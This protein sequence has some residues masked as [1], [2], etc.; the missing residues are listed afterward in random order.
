M[1]PQKISLMGLKE[2][3]LRVFAEILGL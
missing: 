1:V 3:I 2:N